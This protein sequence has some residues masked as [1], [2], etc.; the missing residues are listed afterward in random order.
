M[1]KQTIMAFA[2]MTGGAHAASYCVPSVDFRV[3]AN[4]TIDEDT[5]GLTGQGGSTYNVLT[6]ARDYHGSTYDDTRND[7]DYL[8]AGITLRIPLGGKVCDAAVGQQEAT[9][10]NSRANA[11][12]TEANTLEKMLRLCKDYGPNNP[13]LEGKCN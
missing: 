9:A 1:I 7:R 3:D 13:L 2:L 8:S 4:Q 5:H 11:A 6:D 10:I 12:R